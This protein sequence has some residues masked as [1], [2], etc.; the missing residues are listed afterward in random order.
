MQS[1]QL[2]TTGRLETAAT[3]VLAICAV[4]IT[5]MWAWREFQPRPSLNAPPPPI[6]EDNWEEYAVGDARIGPRDASVVIV[7]FSDFQCPYCRSLFQKIDSVR[8]LYPSQVALVYRNFPLSR[9]HPQAFPAAIAAMCASFQGSFGAYHDALFRRQDSL[10][11]TD[12]ANLATQ[13]GVADTNEFRR[14]LSEPRAARLVRADSVA[15]AKLRVTG[16][17][18]V[19]INGWRI[20]GTPTD[21]ELRRLIARGLSRAK[22]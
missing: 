22:R 19:M 9:I 15:G 2:R 1:S 13:A 7:E 6:L 16:T 11:T 8:S 12:W 4:A 3:G 18:M 14:C 20:N 21:D 5:L 17:P 10:A